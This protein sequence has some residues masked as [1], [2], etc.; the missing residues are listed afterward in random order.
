MSRIINCNADSVRCV[1]SRARS[2]QTLSVPSMEAFT[3]WPLRACNFP[4]H[5][6]VFPCVSIQVHR[7]I[8]ILKK[9]FHYLPLH[10]ACQA[11]K[12]CG[13]TVVWDR[14]FMSDETHKTVLKQATQRALF[15]GLTFFGQGGVTFGKMFGPKMLFHLLSDFFFFICAISY[16]CNL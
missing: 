5:S 16:R 2:T 15:R 11:L 13:V 8:A 10:S 9:T 1:H 4:S 7:K 14:M 6:R 12:R 3:T